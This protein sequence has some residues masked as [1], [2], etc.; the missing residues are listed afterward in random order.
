[1]ERY[2]I[3][4]AQEH[5]SFRLQEFLSVSALLG[6]EI[7]SNSL[8]YS[9]LNPFLVVELPSRDVAVAIANRCVLIKTIHKLLGTGTN[10]AELQQSISS[11]P[12]VVMAE[13]S[14][15]SFKIVVDG[16]N[17]KCSVSRQSVILERLSYLPLHGKVDLSHPDHTFHVLEDYGG[18]NNKAGSEP[19]RVFFTV[20]IAQGQRSLLQQYSVKSRVFIG[21]TS[22]DAQ[23][24]FIMANQAR[25][26]RGQ[27]VCDPFV[28]TG[29]ILVACAHFGA[30]VVGGD[31]NGQLLHGRGRPSRAGTKQKWRGPNE[32]VLANLLQYG[33]EKCYVDV[34]VSD[35]AH[36]IWRSGDLF[37][38]I[39]TDPPY[40]IR[41]GPR[42][43][44]SKRENPKPILDEQLED[45]IPSVCQYQ[46]SD[47]Y[48]DLLL[49]AA[50]FLVLH[51]RLVYWLPIVK[52]QFVIPSHPCLQL[53]ATSE[54]LLRPSIGRLLV[55]MVKVKPYVNPEESSQTSHIINHFRTTYFK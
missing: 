27:L 21:N 20:L 17:K 55:T 3:H 5:P 43:V 48:N 23:L 26:T 42:K 4:F 13:Y 54:Q 53:T 40:G 32:S 39:I 44:G 6:V 11:L 22:M 8:H 52:E 45:H 1:M 33:L 19:E 35:A 2:L 25:V 31:I 12:A 41:E 34:L 38:A 30:H 49:F 15:G 16:F 14:S 9:D 18:D 51:G 24:A 46:L 29:G 28:G 47:V 36:T 50:R 7:S 10:Y 37:D